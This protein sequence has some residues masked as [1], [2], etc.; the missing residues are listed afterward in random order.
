MDKLLFSA[1]LFFKRI[2]SG[3]IVFFLLFCLPSL[4]SAQKLQ[5]FNLGG[6][7][8][9][10]KLQAYNRTVKAD[11]SKREAVIIDEKTGEGI[12][13]IKSLNFTQGIIELDLK[14]QDVLQ[15][16]FVGVAFHGLNDST[17]DAIYFRPF[18][19][20]ATDSVRRIHAVQYISHPAY[21]WKRLRDEQNAKYEKAVN[22]VPDPN[23]WFH[24]RI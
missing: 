8:R 14:G 22:P 6:L 7:F 23:E 12:V 10:G 1:M 4:L 3:I 19:F 21:T 2:R 11:S 24:A 13:W 15:K 18:N 16:S 20:R 17:Y 9:V 5:Q